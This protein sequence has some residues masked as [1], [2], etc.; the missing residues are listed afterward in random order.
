MFATGAIFTKK[1]LRNFL[2]LLGWGKRAALVASRW[3]WNALMLGGSYAKVGAV[4]LISMLGM[5]SMFSAAAAALGGFAAAALPFALLGLLVVGVGISAG[6]LADMLLKKAF[7]G[8]F[9]VGTSIMDKA[10]ADPAFGQEAGISAS[11][12]EPHGG[13]WSGFSQINAGAPTGGE[14]L[15]NTGPSHA[16]WMAL[17]QSLSWYKDNPELP[18]PDVIP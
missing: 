16:W 11:W 1:L 15:T 6:V 17:F 7:G 2:G 5:T 8:G 10:L 9:G 18:T 12:A 4:R 3:G 14:G 13:V